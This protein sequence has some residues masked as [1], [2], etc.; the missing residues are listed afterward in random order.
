MQHE[1]ESQKSRSKGHMLRLAC[2][3][4]HKGSADGGGVL[5]QFCYLHFPHH[6]AKQSLAWSCKLKDKK[7]L[8]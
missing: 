7:N 5:Q 4:D 2:V 1:T 6:F 8:P 3:M